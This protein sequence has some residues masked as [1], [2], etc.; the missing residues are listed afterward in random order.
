MVGPEQIEQFRQALECRENATTSG[1]PNKYGY[2]AT[3]YYNGQSIGHARLSIKHASRQIE[4][5]DFYPFDFMPNLIGN[6]FG[7]VAFKHLMDYAARSWGVD[8]DYS[9]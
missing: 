1:G 2:L 5:I 9:V 7:L 6:G 8:V 4:G 3:F